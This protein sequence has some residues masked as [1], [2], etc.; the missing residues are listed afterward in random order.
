V[1]PL[2]ALAEY[3]IA[4]SAIIKEEARRAAMSAIASAC[5]G[6]LLFKLFWPRFATAAAAAGGDSL[7]DPLQQLL[8]RCFTAESR[9]RPSALQAL[10]VRYM[11]CLCDDFNTSFNVACKSSHHFSL[12][13]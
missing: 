8:S 5:G 2:E 3:T 6:V 12:W 7:P 10:Q 11:H 1:V 9:Q 4:V 13:N